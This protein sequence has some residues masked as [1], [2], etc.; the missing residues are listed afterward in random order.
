MSCH[1]R[2]SPGICLPERIAICKRPASRFNVVPDGWCLIHGLLDPSEIT[3]ANTHTRLRFCGSPLTLAV[4]A[5]HLD[6]LAH[7]AVSLVWN[8]HPQKFGQKDRLLQRI[9]QKGTNSIPNISATVKSNSYE[10]VR[11]I[12]N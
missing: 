3:L 6:A 8:W 12:R 5:P 4:P 1:R 7:H 10:K 2:A 9:T 11:S